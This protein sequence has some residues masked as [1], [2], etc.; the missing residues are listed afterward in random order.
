[1]QTELPL[2]GAWIEIDQ[3]ALAGNMRQIRKMVGEKPLIMPVVKADAYGHGACRCARILLENGADRFAVA[4]L[5]EASALR[6]S[7]ITAPILC[8]GYLPPRQY[9]AAIAYDIAIAVYTWE[10]G[11]ALSRA[12]V[13]AG[14]TATVHIKV[15]SGF[16]R[17][18]L[19]SM[20]I[21]RSRYTEYPSFR[22]LNWKGYSATSQ[23][24]M[25]RT[26]AFAISS[27]H[28]LSGL[29]PCAPKR[30]LPFSCG[31]LPIPRLS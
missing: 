5:Q 8:L 30:E 15:D 20:K 25:K 23:P 13:A 26:K 31:I 22:G 18:G 4:S 7:D 24:P 2:R 28:S 6:D 29:L 14:K 16:G 21:L 17:L 1:M 10:Q 11:L 12:A 9:G 27:M 19:P 3:S